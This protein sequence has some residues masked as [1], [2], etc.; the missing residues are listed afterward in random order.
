VAK[1][2]FNHVSL[3]HVVHHGI[4]PL[5]VWIGT[6]FVA[7]GHS[8]F[9]GLLNTFVHICMYLYYMLSA[10]GPRY[11]KY[12]WWKQHMTTL[13]MVQF[14]GIMVHAFQLIFNEECDFPWQFA[15]YIGAHAVLFFIL[16]S[17]FYIKSYLVK[18]P[19]TSSKVRISFD[20]L[21]FAWPLFL[22]YRLNF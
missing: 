19:P 11:Q 8:S 2:K 6:R 17:E 16:F 4:M 5:S 18:N 20:S 14:V 9:F 12:T 1:K 10:M 15:Y 22:F 3:L 13:Q 7:G 21:I